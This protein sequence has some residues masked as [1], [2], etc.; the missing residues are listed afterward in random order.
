MRSMWNGSITFG[1][2]SVPV[3]MYAATEDHDISFHQVH[4]ADGG[5]IKYLRACTANGEGSMHEVDFADIGKGY[6]APDGSTIIVDKADLDALVTDTAKMITVSQFV[7]AEQIDPLLIGKAYYL[8]PIK[9]NATGYA[10]L[11]QVLESTDRVAIVKVAIRSREQLA[12]L[13]VMRRCL[14]VQT[15]LWPD[16]VR[17]TD[18]IAELAAVIDVEEDNPTL[19]MAHTLI[20]AMTGDFHPERFT[21]EYTVAVRELLDKLI[22]GGPAPTPPVRTDEPRD[23]LMAQLAAS[24]AATKKES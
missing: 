2:V 12:V 15:L 22:A 6:E 14:I 17:S 20:G 13:R 11:R 3:K 16:E 9:G 5:R 7:P 4:V 23:A 18:E 10:L 21:D 24:V 8:G 1:L 19:T